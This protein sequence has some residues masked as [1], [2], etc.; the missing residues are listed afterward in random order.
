[1]EYKILEIRYSQ[2]SP[3]PIL[4]FAQGVVE[5]QLSRP[6]ACCLPGKNPSAALA[7]NLKRT[8]ALEL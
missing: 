6:K 8:K 7:A 5:L 4:V 2:L 3:R 1:M